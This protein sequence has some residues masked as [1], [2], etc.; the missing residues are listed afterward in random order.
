MGDQ[1]SLSEQQRSFSPRATLGIYTH[2]HSPYLSKLLYSVG[3]TVT[4]TVDIRLLIEPGNVHENMAAIASSVDT[5]FFVWLDEDIQFLTDDWLSTLLSHFEDDTIGMVSCTQVKKKE[6]IEPTLRRSSG[7][8][9]LTEVRWTPGHVYVIRT[10][11]LRDGVLPDVKIPGVKGMSDL[12]LCLQVRDRNFKVVVDERVVVWHPWKPDT[13]SFRASEQQPSLQEEKDV[14]P[15]Q[16]DYMLEKWG[17]DYARAVME[18][19]ITFPEEPSGYMRK[20][21]V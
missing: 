15:K 17:D 21:V 7:L 20:A 11:L 6:L 12:D 19:F 9:G 4:E 14:F 8:R 5:E 18:Q 10:S 2:R 3:K 16:R 13:D 1:T